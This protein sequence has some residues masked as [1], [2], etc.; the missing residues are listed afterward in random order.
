MSIKLD[1]KKLLLTGLGALAV[2][3]GVILKNSAEQLKQPESIYGTWLGPAIFIGGW[4]LVAYSISGN[5]FDPFVWLPVI[6]IVAAVMMMMMARKKKQTPSMIW[7]ILFIV[8][9]L[10]FAYGVGK[11]NNIKL[12]LTFGSTM[13]V[14]ASMLYFLPKQREKC[15]VDGPGFTLFTLAW[16]GIAIANAM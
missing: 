14:F 12:F 9:W 13:L 15:V 11:G 5:R 1:Q 2:I 16:V 7:G 8:G 3:T 10:A 4:A 6:G